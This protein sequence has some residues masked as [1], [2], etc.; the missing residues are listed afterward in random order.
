MAVIPYSRDLCRA[1][2][3]D[4]V[5]G[6]DARVV[7]N[8]VDEARVAAPL[9]LHAEDIEPWHWS[10]AAGVDDLAPRIEDGDAQPRIRAAVAGRPDDR[11]DPLCREVQALGR[12]PGDRPGRPE[13]LGLPGIETVIQ[14]VRI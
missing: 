4:D 5:P 3:V 6:N 7:A 12:R 13:R 9:K 8:A 2:S 1:E 11:V 10:D 14:D